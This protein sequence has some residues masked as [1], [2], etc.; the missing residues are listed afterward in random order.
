MAERVTFTVDAERSTV[1]IEAR[2]SVHPVRGQTN[3]IEGTVELDLDGDDVVVPPLPA[4]R[5]EL[6][7]TRLSSGNFLYDNEMR[8]RIEAAKFP[9]I[10]GELSRA[11]TNGDG[12]FEVAGQLTFHGQTREVEADIVANVD[13]G[14]LVADWDQTID[15]RDFGVE[16]PRILLLRV[17]PE[18]RVTVHIEAASGSAPDA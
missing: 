14:R 4:A 15:I 5:I 3:G 1:A 12:T 17:Y 11:S 7:V 6:P 2:S 9:T 8:R 18:V 10:V 13:D 16:P